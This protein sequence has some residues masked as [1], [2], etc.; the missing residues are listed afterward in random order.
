MKKFLDNKRNKT[1]LIG[2]GVFSIY[3]VVTL[4]KG[5]PLNW[6]DLK[7]LSEFESLLYSLLIS[8]MMLGVIIY[9]YNEKLKLMYKD[10]KKNHKKYFSKYIKYWLAALFF[11]ALSNLIILSF[12]DN[13]IPNNEQ[14]IRMFFN[15]NPIM[16]FLSAVIIAPILEELVFRQA[17]R[18]MFSDDIMF[19]FMSAATFGLFHVIGSATSL[20]DLVYIIPYTIP[21]IAFSLMLKETDNIIVPMGF[22]FLHNGILIALQFVLLI[23]G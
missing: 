16:I 22:H 1:T 4:L 19:I 8:A 9:I 3:F 23:F 18:D 14:I 2:I 20:F 7:D 12:K 21:G 5:I 6:L 17:F 15:T 10:I 11:M 13:A